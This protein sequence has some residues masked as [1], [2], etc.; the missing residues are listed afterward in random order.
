MARTVDDVVARRTRAL[1]LDAEATVEIAPRVAR[2]LARELGRSPEWEAEQLSS[3][4]PIGA[5]GLIGSHT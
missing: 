3:F 5:I 1:F 2:L 4:A